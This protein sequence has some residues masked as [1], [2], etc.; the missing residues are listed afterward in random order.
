MVILS[1]DIFSIPAGAPQRRE[2]ADDDR[3]RPSRAPAQ[4]VTARVDCRRG[5]R[6]RRSSRLVC[7]GARW[8]PAAPTRYGYVSQA[9]LWR[10][11]PADRA[12]GRRRD[13]R[14]GRGAAETWTPLGYRPSPHQ[15]GAIVPIYAP[16]LPLLMAL[17]Q[18]VGGFCAAF[19]VVPLCGALTVWLTFALGR[20]VFETPRRRLRRRAARRDEPGVPVSTDERDER[21]AGDRV[22]GAGARSRARRAVR[23]RPVSR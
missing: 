7:A 21:R 23:S 15:R 5:A 12:A 11:R 19:L 22:R 3:R 16:G 2:G 20:R 1:D 13:R 6:G 10:R 4:S 9:G 17:L 18:A 8:S 14:R